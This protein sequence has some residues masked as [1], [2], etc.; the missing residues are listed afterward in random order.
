MH[1]VARDDAYANLLLP[2]RIRRARLTGSDAGFATELTY[3]T[4]R[5]RGLYDAVIARAAGRTIDRIDP[6]ALDVLRLG[7]HQLLGMETPPHAAVDESVRLARQVGAPR[8]AGFVNAVLRRVGERS[9]D[10]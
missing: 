2:T 10:E 9:L 5:S 7:A 4:L 1:A 6:L 8:A 3:G